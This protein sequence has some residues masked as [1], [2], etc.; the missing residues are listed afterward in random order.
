[1]LYD[2]KALYEAESPQDACRLLLEHPGSRVLAGGS[3]VLIKLREGKYR[4]IE[5]VSIYMLD[6]LRGIEREADGTIR[7]GSLCN[8][9]EVAESPLVR[10]FAPVL[11]EAVELIGGPQ[12]RNIGTIGGNTCNGVT[13]ADSAATLLCYDAEVELLSTNGTRLLPLED[14]YLGPG[15]VDLKPGEIQTA[16]LIREPGYAGYN[17]RFIKYA[18]R[19]AMDIATIGCSVQIRLGDDTFEDIRLAYGVANPVPSRARET[20]D[21]AR[22]LEVTDDTIRRIAESARDEMNPRN[23]WRAS[24]D[25]R[26]HLIK[27]CTERALRSAV[28][29]A[30]GTVQ[31]RQ[32]AQ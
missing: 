1:M 29:R 18:M 16:I 4:G 27:V 32:A 9:R 13:S 3:D 6:E 28:E 22:G 21:K 7:I 14:F 24:K 11:A 5:L 25:F 12:V 15:K 8:F 19:D 30:G 26:E 31:S 23:S 17:G 10:E 2:F 20:E